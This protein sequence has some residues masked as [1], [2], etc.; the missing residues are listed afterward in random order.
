MSQ[1][2]QDVKDQINNALND[3]SKP[4]TQAFDIIEAKTGVN[5]LYAFIGIVGIVALWLVFGYASQLLCNLIGFVYPLFASMKALETL[6][7]EDDTKWLTYWVVFAAFSLSEFFADLIVGWFPVYWLLKCLFLIWCMIPSELNGSVIIYNRL[8]RPLFLKH[9]GT[10]DHNV[11]NLTK[12]AKKFVADHLAK[13][14]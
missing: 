12:T 2:V 5:R 11:D 1:K 9:Q 4:W 10:I 14:D 8:L 3:R 13:S 7:R 6:N